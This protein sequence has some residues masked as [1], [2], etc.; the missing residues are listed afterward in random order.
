VRLKEHGSELIEVADNGCGVRPDGY[1]ALTLK[2][3]TSKLRCFGDLQARRRRAA[4]PA[5]RAAARGRGGSAA[6]EL[7][8]FGFRGEALSSLCALADVSV[9]TRTADGAAGARLT[10]DHAGRLA[11][12]AAAARA[13]GTTVAVRE[14]FRT[15]PVRFKARRA[16]SGS[17]RRPACAYPETARASG[18]QR[19]AR[20]AAQEFR[21]NVKREY[22]KLLSVLQAYALIATGVRIIC[23]NHVRGAPGPARPATAPGAPR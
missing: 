4:A 3:H 22:A 18:R 23:T 11:G 20:A 21:R 10:Y 5:R 16:A 17:S 15:L 1:Q 14:L 6:Q 9:V 12:T 8:T 19:R 13:P 2:Y 7:A